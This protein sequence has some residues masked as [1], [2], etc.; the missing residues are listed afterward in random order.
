MRRGRLILLALIPIEIAILYWLGGTF[1]RY[2]HRL[3]TCRRHGIYGWIWRDV[4]IRI[5]GSWQFGQAGDSL[6]CVWDLELNN[7]SRSDTVRLYQIVYA[8][9]NRAG[10]ELVAHLQASYPATGTSGPAVSCL[11]IP[12]NETACLKHSFG[13]DKDKVILVAHA[14]IRLSAERVRHGRPAP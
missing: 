6:A 5:D 9:T 14:H 11:V 2:P 8:F 1:Y 13:M 12:P 4:P 10:N 7:Y 3:F